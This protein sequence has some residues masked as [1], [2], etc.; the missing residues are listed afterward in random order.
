MKKN[1]IIISAVFIFMFSA[2]TNNFE[3]I[4][5]N[6][7]H[8]PTSDVNYIFNYVI[9]EGAGE[10]GYPTTYNYSFV[11]RWIMQTSVVYGNSTM[12]PYTL[13]DDT[14]IT[15]LW[16]YFYSDLLLNCHLLEKE[17]SDNPDLLNKHQVARIWK[18]YCFHRVTDLWGD[19]PY[20]DAWKFIQEYSD[21]T[22]SPKYDP[23][24]EIYQDMI[25]VLKDAAEK[26]DVS[27][28]F[29]ATDMIFGGDLEL[30]VKFA[31]SLRLRLAVRSRNELVVSEIISEDN[32]ISATDEGAIFQYISS[33]IWWNP[34]YEMNQNSKNPSLPDYTGLNVPRISRLMLN[35]LGNTGDPRL[36]VF[37][38]P[39]EIDNVTYTGVPNLMN[40][41]L[42]ENQALNMSIFNT[43]YIG[44]HFSEDPI[45]TKQFLGYAEVCFLRSEAAFRDWTAETPNTWYEEGVRSSMEFYEIPEASIDTFL[46]HGG[47]WGDSLEQI[48]TQKWVAQFLDG[49]ETFSEYRRTGYP[50]L[51]KY[52]LVLD[53]NDEILDS[54]WVDVPRD[55]LPG[56]LPYPDIE[57]DLN[58]ENYL[59]AVQRQWG[60]GE[61]Y[62]KRQLWWAT[63][64]GEVDYTD[65]IY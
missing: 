4:N 20:S 58:R 7:N 44:R 38:Q 47:A 42:K 6:P 51:K 48:I 10:Y 1:N 45:L 12:P 54:A 39:I 14:R 64:F 11:Q 22:I 55:Y 8:P 31:N 15:N 30:W 9:K 52:E 18:V 40:S 35:Q 16:N 60:E 24:E 17:T 3:D 61:D 56:R 5:T 23:Q 59:E 57:V 37:V 19:V 62:Y 21:E 29:Y 53:G 27:G 63:K 13:F 2:C 41:V 65:D 34:Y 46:A 28:D 25:S 32:L 26:I 49:W 50:Q 33:Q 43:S 36:S